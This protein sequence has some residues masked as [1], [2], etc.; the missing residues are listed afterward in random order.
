MTRAIAVLGIVGCLSFAAPGGV[1]GADDDPRRPRRERRYGPWSRGVNLGP[2]VNTS[3]ADQAPAISADGLALY[4]H[5]L[6]PGS[7]AGPTGA[8][9]SDIWVA[10]R[11]AVD[12]PWETPVNLGPTINTGSHEVGPYASA[13][14]HYLFFS[15]S[16]TD[17]PGR[18]GSQDIYVSRRSDPNDDFGW[19]TPVALTD[20]NSTSLDGHPHYFEAPL[21]NPQLYFASD[22]LG[23][24]DIFLTELQKDGSWSAP[25]PVVELNSAGLDARPSVR[26]DGLEILFSTDRD[27]HEDLY[28]SRRERT[29]E[30]WGPPQP[31]AG[32]VNTASTEQLPALS[33]DGRTLYYSVF[34][35]GQFDLYASTRTAHGR[36]RRD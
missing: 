6:R 26:F 17:L 36:A 4:F 28:V 33:I 9:S 34:S 3:A 25:Q 8:P 11:L 7:I 19:G 32:G 23:S 14:G 22:R 35:N 5:S 10:R 18:S 15:T 27:G 21:G 20:V 31:V 16:R 2:I 29:W 30:P 24:R 12:L 13:D 1:V